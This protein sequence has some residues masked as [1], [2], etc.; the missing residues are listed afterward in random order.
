MTPARSGAFR[1]FSFRGI[2]VF[3][4]WWWFVLAWIEI[5]SRQGLY[6]S[7]IWNI[8][9]YIGLFA[10]VLFHEVG[11]AFAFR[12]VGGVA[13]EIILWPR[14]GIAFAK[15]PPRVKAE[16]WTIAAGPLVNVVLFPVL[17]LAAGSMDPRTD[18]GLLV[19][20]LWTINKWL[21]LFNLLP[22][23]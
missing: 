19:F 16:L 7:I 2:D 21:L 5:S 4:H 20:M 3:L 17:M 23:Y 10:I 11:H 14:G 12:S 18:L 1:I 22:I 8:A 13:N 15:P 9:E 6:T